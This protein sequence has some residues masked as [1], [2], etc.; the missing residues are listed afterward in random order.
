MCIRDRVRGDLVVDVNGFDCKMKAMTADLLKTLKESRYPH[1]YIRIRQLD[2]MP[3]FQRSESIAGNA[4]ITLAGATAGYDMNFNFTKNP[5]GTFILSGKRKV[6][7][8][9]FKI[10]PPSKVG[11]MIKTNQELEVQFKVLFFKLN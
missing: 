6:K 5:N 2:R 3:S 11:G 1:F 8:S 9:D 10:I 7:F 4:L